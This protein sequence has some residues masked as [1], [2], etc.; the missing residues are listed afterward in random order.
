M[1]KCREHD[2]FD[3]CCY[4]KN[5]QLLDGYLKLLKIFDK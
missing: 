2:V 1:L 4:I 3:V 5:K